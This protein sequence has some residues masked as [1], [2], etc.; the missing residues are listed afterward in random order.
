MTG[1]DHASIAYDVLAP[2]YDLLTGGH[3]HGVWAAQLESFAQAAGLSGRRLLDIGCGTGSSALPMLERG[4]AVTGVD[5]SA[6]MLA[7]AREKLGPHVRLE[8]ADMRTLPTFGAFDLIWSVAD[9]VNCLLDVDE[10]EAAFAGL[11]RNLAPGGVVVFD[12]DTLA[13]FRTLYSSLIVVP[14]ADGLV[15]FDGQ[16]DRDL[17]P[18][19]AASAVVEHLRPA[20]DPPWWTRSRALHRQR[21]HSRAT[22]ERALYAAGLEC[23]AVWGTDGR[24]GSTPALDE[25]THNKAVYVARVVAS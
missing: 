18:D 14:G 25:L 7:H 10:L 15:L 4:Y 1:D 17:A 6:E 8:L 3:D 16:A 24:G 12:V 13:S 9:G 21:H 11:R 23:V 5:V 19:C 2:V 22:L 20:A